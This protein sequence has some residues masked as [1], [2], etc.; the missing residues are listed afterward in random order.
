MRH[1]TACVPWSSMCL[2]SLHLASI[3]PPQVR[4]GHNYNT[5]HSSSDIFASL[6]DTPIL[7]KRYSKSIIAITPPCSHCAL[8]HCWTCRSYY[9]LYTNKNS[10]DTLRCLVHMHTH[11]TWMEK[12]TL[13]P[14]VR[15]FF[16]TSFLWRKMSP[17]RHPIRLRMRGSFLC[18]V[19][20][21]G[22][23]NGSLGRTGQAKIHS[24]YQPPSNEDAMKH[25]ETQWADSKWLKHIETINM[26]RKQWSQSLFPAGSLWH[27]PPRMLEIRGLQADQHP[28]P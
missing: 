8:L 22:R 4:N 26:A 3:I 24:N 18:S 17:Q 27:S 21:S 6:K 10:L 16:S 7:G 19:P 2:S 9:I 14:L 15:P 23:W 11:C 25:N 1:V 5:R 20:D 13:F 28:K 12:V